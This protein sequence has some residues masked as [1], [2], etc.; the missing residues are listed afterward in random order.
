M[1]ESCEA[2]DKRIVLLARQL[3]SGGAERQLVALACGLKD[4]GCDVRVVLFYGGGVFDAELVAAQVPVY[5]VEKRG[6][7]DVVGF[8]F[9]LVGTL[10]QLEP[11]VIYS[12]LDLPNVLA[13]LL[14]GFVGKPLLIWS[15]RAAGME[16]LHYDWL[17]RIVPWVEARLSGRPRIIIANSYAGAAWAISR[18][19]PR[20]RLRVVHNGIDTVRFRPDAIGRARV[21]AEWGVN[22]STVLVGLVARL[23]PMKDHRL[24]FQSCAALKVTQDD[25]RFV[26]VGG[27]ST[28]YQDELRKFAQQLGIGERVIWAGGRQ[29]MPAVHSALDMECSTSAFGEGFSNA[30]GEAMACGVPCVVTDVGDSARIVMDVGE[31]LAPRDSAA[32]T[33]A[34]ERLLIRIKNEPRLGER[35][36]ERIQCEFSLEQMVLRTEQILLARS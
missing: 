20:E 29:D 27:G 32:L 13:S 25:V 23:D 14:S 24:F 35:A 7:W 15:V 9:R 10:R 18:R 36:R 1:T 34:L 21:R 4:R 19:F 6:R 2:I 30:I 8:L 31:V 3:A 26:C 5:F 16:M 12:F 17:M 22:D 28:A 33:R 11:K